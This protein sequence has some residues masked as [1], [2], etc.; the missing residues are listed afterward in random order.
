M[1]VP[2]RL[3][4]TLGNLP[5]DVDVPSALM[6]LA[7]QTGTKIVP[8]D[9]ELIA[10]HEWQIDPDPKALAAR[11]R[12]WIDAQREPISFLAPGSAVA[13]RAGARLARDVLGKGAERAA[14]LA[15]AVFAL[16]AIGLG[17]Y[18][19]PTAGLL[20]AS[21]SALLMRM[22]AVVERVAQLGRAQTG[23]SALHRVLDGLLDPV[24]VILLYLAAPEDYGLLRWFIP[25]ILIGQ[26]R[27]AARFS[28]EKWKATYEDRITLALILAC[29][30]FWGFSVEVS[31]VLC[32][33]VLAS[34]F[35][36]A[37]RDK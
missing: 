7:L 14:S 18:F 10:E 20:L 15:G 8:L 13:E 34:R 25:L 9:R 16:L 29:G 28:S 27:L 21:G 26:L 11:E 32:L 17:A 35:F 30:A 5:Q 3:I 4:R 24:I 6:R 31:A 19:S 33:L 37:F 12:K 36:T 23:P 22:G 1:L 2:G